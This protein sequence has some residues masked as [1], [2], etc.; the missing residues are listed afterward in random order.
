MSATLHLPELAL[1]GHLDLPSTDGRIV[2]N[3]IEQH[4]NADLTSSI[5]PLMMVLH[6]D[7]DY[8]IGQD[9][10]IYYRPTDPPL[11]GCKAPDWFYVPNVSKFASDGEVRLSYVMWRERKA[12]YLI[13]EQVSGDGSE[14]RDDTP[15]TGKFWVYEQILQ[16]PYYAIFDGFEGTLECFQLVDDVYLPMR[17]NARSHFE[18]P[19]LNVELGLWKGLSH[20]YYRHWLRFFDAEGTMLPIHAERAERANERAEQEEAQAKRAMALAAQEKE[21]ADRANE[22]AEK[23][24]AQTK[25]AN[26]LATREKERADREKERAE[27]EKALATREKERADRANELADKEKALAAQ[28][29][30]RAD[31]ATLE[32]ARLREQLARLGINP[33]SPVV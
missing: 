6:P 2:E 20:N 24:E 9:V 33:G 28:E 14:E 11:Q 13:V 25:R 22:R 10:G 31:A 29:K 18:L 8:F 19:F 7:G 17:A 30:E 15:N 23:E 26:A 32:I 5:E 1:P 16:V 12:P 27:K 4:Q 3:S 21:R